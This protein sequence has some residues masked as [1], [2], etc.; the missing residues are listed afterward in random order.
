MNKLHISVVLDEGAIMPTKAHAEDAG[1]DLYLP[2]NVKKVRIW[3]G[4]HKVIDTGVHFSIPKGY[5]GFVKSKSG[6]SV[7][8]CL[9]HGAGVVDAGYT[10]SVAV[11]LYN[12]GCEPYEFKAGDKLAQIVFLPIPDVEL[13]LNDSLADTERGSNGFGSSGR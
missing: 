10:G 3:K 12:Y 1:F 5:V 8:Y 11:H 6:L 7:K 9:E 2:S 4:D 13:E